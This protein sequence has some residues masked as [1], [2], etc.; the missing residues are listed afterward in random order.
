MFAALGGCKPAEVSVGNFNGAPRGLT[1]TTTRCPLTMSIKVAA[2]ER[3]QI[4]WVRFRVDLLAA[5]PL[6][7]YKCLEKRHV[8][9]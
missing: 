6:I 7:C 9:D 4:A 1:I 8:R 2:A 3:I 5:R